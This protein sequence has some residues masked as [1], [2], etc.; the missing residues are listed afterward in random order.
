M[1]QYEQL[2]YHGKVRRL[3]QVAFNALDCYDLRVQRLS[4]A[5]WYT[6]V[7]FRVDSSDG[8]RS[9]LRLCA[10]GWRTENDLRSEV[11]WLNSLALEPHI[12]APQP[13]PAKDGQ[14]LV[15]AQAPG[16]MELLFVLMSWVPGKPLGS[17]LSEA[18]L[19]K[20]GVLFARMHNHGEAFEPP[21]GFTTR[22]MDRVLARGEADV[23]FASEHA[24][25]FSIESRAIFEQV[26]LRVEETYAKR[27]GGSQ[28][29][30]VIHHDLWHDNIHLYR[31]EL[32]PLDFEDTV[33]GFPV[34]DIAM[35]MQ[36]LMDD[37][38]TERYEPLLEAFRTG[39][40]GL[41]AWPEAYTSEMDT[42]RAGRM[43]WTAN[44][45]ANWHAQMLPKLIAGMTPWLA[46][47]LETG[48]LR[49]CGS[50]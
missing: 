28:R 49:K 33:W 24:S 6:N 22:K 20:M 27:Y 9:M 2:T 30:I 40:T 5:G 19:H 37:V 16:M 14:Y 38:P 43:L 11:A 31:G 34:Q 41:R 46:N 12:H 4:L 39:Y 32:Y 15:R 48:K 18:N 26:R 17:Q 42:F 3:R 8:K 47:F 23:L 50:Q 1:K 21:E 44:W 25:S 35:A 7:M 13:Q 36:D 45:H 10:P 29:P